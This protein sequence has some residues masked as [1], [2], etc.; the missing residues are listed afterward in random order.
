MNNRKRNYSTDNVPGRS[1]QNRRPKIETEGKLLSVQHKC[2]HS[3]GSSSGKL[4]ICYK[5][6]EQLKPVYRYCS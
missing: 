6:S 1:G 4:I 3:Q 5:V 2:F